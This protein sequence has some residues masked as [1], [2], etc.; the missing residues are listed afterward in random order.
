MYTYLCARSYTLICV[1]QRSVSSKHTRTCLHYMYA[2][3]CLYV[4]TSANMLQHVANICIHVYIYIYIHVCIHTC[5]YACM[6]T[7]MH[8]YILTHVH[9]YLTHT[10]TPNS[11]VDILAHTLWVALAEL[12]GVQT[13]YVWKRTSLFLTL[14]FMS[15][16]IGLQAYGHCDIFL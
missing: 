13:F 3:P 16:A 1:W 11:H 4:C 10:H 8:T 6:H 14:I 5:M 7:Y 9:I 2:R 12:V 15:S